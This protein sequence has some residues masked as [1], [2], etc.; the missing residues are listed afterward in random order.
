MATRWYTDPTNTPDVSPAFV[1]DIWTDT[2]AAVRR[3][4]VID[5]PGNNASTNFEA[6]ETSGSTVYKLLVQFVSEPLDAISATAASSKGAFRC[7][8]SAAK[9]DAFLYILPGK[10]DGDGANETKFGNGFT[11]YMFDGTEFDDGALVNRATN[12]FNI[13][14]QVFSQGDRLIMEVGV[15]LSNSKTDLYSGTVNITDNHV[16]TDLPENDTETTAY[17]SWIET[18]DTFTVAA[19]G[20]AVAPTSVLYGPF[21]G[22]LGGPV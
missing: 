20:G 16:D 2:T 10:C 13:D 15:R 6:A 14:D 22:P 11:Y 5:T 1:G 12:S 3:K 8:E 21:V 19:V 9:S 4:L 17:N 7:I 18:G